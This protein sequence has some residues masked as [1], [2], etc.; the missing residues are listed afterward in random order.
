MPFSNEQPAAYIII[1]TSLMTCIFFYETHEHS[2]HMINRNR[3]LIFWAVSPTSLW[4]GSFLI[5]RSVLRILANFASNKGGWIW[6]LLVQNKLK[7][8][9]NNIYNINKKSRI[10][11]WKNSLNIDLKHRNMYV[12]SSMRVSWASMCMKYEQ[13]TGRWERWNPYFL[14]KMSSSTQPFRKTA[15]VHRFWWFDR[16]HPVIRTNS[17]NHN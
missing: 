7:P 5:S 2:M 16:I 11:Y 9:G 14:V 15:G 3:T 8:T 13:Q 6:C 17:P 12:H 4:N 1:T 10:I